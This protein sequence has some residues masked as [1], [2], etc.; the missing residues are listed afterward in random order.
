MVEQ[1]ERVWQMLFM[2]TLLVSSRS[3]IIFVEQGNQITVR[4]II[5]ETPSVDTRVC[6]VSYKAAVAQVSSYT[7]MYGLT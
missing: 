7:I 3:R 4:M 2:G 5:I 6:L 1:R